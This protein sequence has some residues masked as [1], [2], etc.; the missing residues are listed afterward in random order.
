MTDNTVPRLHPAWLESAI[1][2]NI[3][4][5]VVVTNHHE[6]SISSDF[7]IR[8]EEAPIVG[9]SIVYAEQMTGLVT[10]AVDDVRPF[11]GPAAGFSEQ[12]SITIYAH[13]VR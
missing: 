6:L 9:D 8:L 11:H 13:I 10:L 5:H 3:L 1:V 4:A 7:R 12:P 2:A